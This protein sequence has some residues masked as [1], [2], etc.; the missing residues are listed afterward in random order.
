VSW[1]SLP[2]LILHH[3]A[4]IS[5]Y[6]NGRETTL[7]GSSGPEENQRETRLR[8]CTPDLQR[9]ARVFE[10]AYLPLKDSLLSPS[11]DSVLT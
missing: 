11:G 9:K 5:N 8:F 1:L 6:R 3:T 2:W 7:S 10:L 4:D